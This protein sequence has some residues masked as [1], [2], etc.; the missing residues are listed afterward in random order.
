MVVVTIVPNSAQHPLISVLVQQTARTLSVSHK[1]E[2]DDDYP[3][4]VPG[5]TNDRRET[6]GER[7]TK[8]NH[9]VV[10]KGFKFEDHLGAVSEGA[11]M[12]FGRSREKCPVDKNRSFQNTHP[13]YAYRRPSVG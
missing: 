1:L 11:G 3:K 9:Y 2:P 12:S 6:K 4:R 5:T 13:T 8:I 7:H 10:G